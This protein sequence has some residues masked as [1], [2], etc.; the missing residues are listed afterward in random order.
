MIYT[1]LLHPNLVYTFVV[2]IMIKKFLVMITW[3][4]CAGGVVIFLD[5][6]I[7]LP[8]EV[9][10]VLYFLSIGIAASSVLNYYK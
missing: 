3:M 4:G 2:V 9:S 1:F 10:G 5:Y 8:D 7:V 6:H